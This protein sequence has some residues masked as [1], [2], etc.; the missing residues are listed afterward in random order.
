[1]SSRLEVAAVLGALVL[2]GCSSAA[3]S[4]SASPAFTPQAECERTGGWWRAEMNFCE[5]EAP[6]T[7]PFPRPVR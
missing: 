7:T 5:Y 2:A 4:G 6:P 3:T 1:M